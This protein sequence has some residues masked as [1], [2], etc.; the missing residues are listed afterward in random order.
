M[1]QENPPPERDDARFREI[2]DT[3]AHL[4]L[5]RR[6]AYLDEACGA[7][8][9]LRAEVESLLHTLDRADG[10]LANPTVASEPVTTPDA[11]EAPGERIGRYKLLEKLGEGGMGVV[12][13]AEQEHPVVRR[14]AVKVIKLGMDTRQ[15]IARFEAERQALAMM[16]H[17]NIARVLDAGATDAGRPYFVMELVRGVSITDYCDGA[18]LS[19]RQRLELFVPV[20]RAVQHAHQKGVI[21]RDLKPSNVLVTLHDGVPVP[22]VIDF[23]VAKATAGRLTEKTVYTEFHQFVGTPEY[24]SP[25]QA[26]MSGLD[27]DTRADVYALGVLLYEL[28][29]GTTP[30]DGKELR[31]AAYAEIQ[32]I[33]REVEP[34]RPSTRLST[35]GE[36]LTGVAARRGIEPKKLGALLRGDLDWIVMK[37]LEKD[38]TRRYETA[39]GIAADVQRY[40]KDEPVEAS[41]PSATYRLRKLARKHR[42]EATALVAIAAALVLG[43][44]GTSIGMVRAGLAVGRAKTAET[45]AEQRKTAAENALKDATRNAARADAVNTFMK[46]V[47]A[48]PVRSRGFLRP[49]DVR[50]VSVLEEVSLLLDTQ[51]K[52][53]PAARAQVRD[54]IGMTY[55]GMDRLVDAERELRF[56]YESAITAEGEE[57]EQSLAV[58]VHLALVLGRKQAEPEQFNNGFA[59]FKGHEGPQAK[60][61]ALAR[62]AYEIARR[63]FGADRDV[64]VQA[65]VVLAS[66][67]PRAADAAALLE[68]F[69]GKARQKGENNETVRALYHA[70][71]RALVEMGRLEQAEQILADLIRLFDGVPGSSW[72]VNEAEVLLLY[73]Q[74]LQARGKS[75]EAKESYRR[76]MS[77]QRERLDSS[78]PIVVDTMS[79]YAAFLEGNGDRRGA[80]AVHRE[81]MDTWRKLGRE[82]TSSYRQGLLNSARLLLRLGATDEAV[83]AENEAFIGNQVQAGSTP[84]YWIYDWM[85]ELLAEACGA[86]SAWESAT[87]RSNVWCALFDHLLDEPGGAGFCVDAIDW[88][89][90][91]FRLE[92]WT[93]DAGYFLVRAGEF[94]G[95]RHVPDQPPGIYRLT[96][97]L[98]RSVS[99][100]A[101]R[102][103]SWLLYAPWDVKVHGPASEPD[104]TEAYQ[105]ILR[106]PAA[107]QR[108][109]GSIAFVNPARPAVFV[110]PP[111]YAMIA[112][113]SV[114]L[115]AGRYRFSTTS[116]SGLRLYVDGRLAI[117]CWVRRGDPCTDDV[118][119]DLTAG[120]HAVRVESIQRL[121]AS[122]LWVRIAPTTQPA[123]TTVPVLGGSNRGIRVAVADLESRLSAEIERR[124]NTKDPL[125]VRARFYAS[126]ARFKES[127]ED[128]AR[129][130]RLDP[131]DPWDWLNSALV[132]LQA[133][134][135]D[136]YRRQCRDM[137]S[138][139]AASDHKSLC[140]VVKACTVIPD[141]VP[142][143]GAVMALADRCVVQNYDNNSILEW[144]AQ[145][146]GVAEYR[147]GR[148]DSAAE[149]LA[150][151]V[152][153]FNHIPASATTSLYLAM[154]EFKRGRPAA[155]RE[156]FRS[157]LEVLQRDGPQDG[158]FTLMFQEWIVVLHAQREAEA[159]LGDL[160][161]QPATQEVRP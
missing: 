84:T 1:P 53:Q 160:A 105:A 49:D 100:E 57:G 109:I 136:E 83:R 90:L 65:A 93:P 25:E 34:P 143:F 59:V 36:T 41:P 119:L 13:V 60:G 157:A 125:L 144:R 161:R 116:E 64:T 6:P 158:T 81:L 19:P 94:R 113:T 130:L 141:A 69:V 99:R 142:D 159:L 66:Y 27:I 47:L 151:G 61:E 138:R 131:S 67:L 71:A 45:L 104:P 85:K 21:H 111:K 137:L 37:C 87:L 124:P 16:D 75:T 156:A 97:D 154:A 133:G 149:W 2:L 95:L 110:N 129:V 123:T 96:M 77:L 50:V 112:S 43:I 76:A 23:G 31:R 54:T 51:L 22:K 146:K 73:A 117:D 70:N 103:E 52:D 121:Y 11:H 139:F 88:D 3:A 114:E 14:V 56:A 5:D 55:C 82:D 20:C 150:K 101:Q 7:D 118:V 115:P 33:I 132:V 44:L 63:R 10:I 91:R 152:S 46:K 127:A 89:E 155:A 148:F 24:M 9:G 62:K 39:N 8:D 4:P 106:M 12:Y 126:R 28:L 147:A 74:T 145:A 72:A 92:R 15:V 58:A 26:E 17:P 79:Q 80:L 86:D 78:H 18:K 68:E 102:V 120:P 122:H 48:S 153:V 134:D 108:T 98:S 29:T 107:E 140:D 128:Y 30:F 32:R 40:L 135:R 42:K 38:R 35:L